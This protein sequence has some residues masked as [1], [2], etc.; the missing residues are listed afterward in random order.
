MLALRKCSKLK[1][2]LFQWNELYNWD[3]AIELKELDKTDVDAY[4]WGETDI[5]E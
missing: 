3:K 2:G 5:D 1:T 4:Y